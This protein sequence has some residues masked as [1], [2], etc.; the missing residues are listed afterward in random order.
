MSPFVQSSSNHKP[1]SVQFCYESYHFVPA[2]LEMD[3][4]KRLFN[5]DIMTKRVMNMRR[6][7]SRKI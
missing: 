5:K 2:L 7:V 3:K 1:G 4:S 6:N